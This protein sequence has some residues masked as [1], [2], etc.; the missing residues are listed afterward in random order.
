MM[1]W[2]KPPLFAGALS[3]AAAAAAA[4]Y[5]AFADSYSTARCSG[6][7]R[8][9]AV[10]QTL[11]E[12]NGDWVFILIL[13]PVGFA[14]ALWAALALGLPNGLRWTVVS[15]YLAFCFITGFS[16]GLFYW[17]SA[18]L[19]VIAAALASSPPPPAGAPAEG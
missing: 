8:C 9:A 4:A 12:V 13:V 17:P 1:V 2:M 3:V 7:G 14:I 16:I 10:G 15:V 18:F 11:G 5:W 6:P 19:A